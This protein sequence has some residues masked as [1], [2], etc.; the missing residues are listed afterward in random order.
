MLFTFS[1]NMWLHL[2]GNVYP[3]IFK[4]LFCDTFWRTR[5]HNLFSRDDVIY[6]TLTNNWIQTVIYAELALLT[7][8]CILHLLPDFYFFKGTS[9]RV[10]CTDGMTLRLHS[11]FSIGPRLFTSKQE[12][13]TRIEVKTSIMN[14][15]FQC[16]AFA[17]FFKRI[18]S[19]KMCL[20]FCWRDQNTELF[21]WA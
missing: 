4:P 6:H 21:W 18:L 7:S 19:R 12:A 2:Y 11:F 10:S 20:V 8:K 16:D 14:L 13:E 15:K 5:N 9:F 1:C 17:Y 3:A